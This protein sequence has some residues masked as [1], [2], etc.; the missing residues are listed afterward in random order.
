M[1][2]GG[3]MGDEKNPNPLHKLLQDNEEIR[4]TLQ[5]LL[6]QGISVD[7]N[8]NTTHGATINK[9]SVYQYGS[10]RLPV[11]IPDFDGSI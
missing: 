4:M 9:T 10:F 3:L 2:N 7:P 11:P 8:F 5:K 6:E 1:K